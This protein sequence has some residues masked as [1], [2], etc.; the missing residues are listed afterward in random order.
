MNW[1]VIACALGTL[2]L[3]AI[4]GLVSVVWANTGRITVQEE[5]VDGLRKDIA[6]MRAAL[7]KKLDRL[8]DRLD[9]MS[10]GK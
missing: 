10:K 5:R 6:E 4:I 8:E 7:E 9:Q 2:S 1:K 3:T